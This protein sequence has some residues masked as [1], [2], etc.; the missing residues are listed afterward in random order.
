MEEEKINQQDKSPKQNNKPSVLKRSR[1]K[2]ITRS[3]NRPKNRTNRTLSDP[4]DG[5]N[6]SLHTI[7]LYRA[8]NYAKIS[9]EERVNLSLGELELVQMEVKNKINETQCKAQTYKYIN[10]IASSIV[11]VLSGAITAIEATSGDINIPII[12][13]GSIIFVTEGMH[14]LFGWGPRG[15]MYKEGNSQLRKMSRTIRNHLYFLHQYSMDKILLVVNDMRQQYDDIES[16]L[17]KMSSGENVTYNKNLDLEQGGGSLGVLQNNLLPQNSVAHEH[18][19]PSPHVHIHIE[20]SPEPN[21]LRRHSTTDIRQKNNLLNINGK[22]KPL[23]I[24]VDNNSN[25]PNTPPLNF[26]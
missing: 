4:N 25:N 17:Y 16:F 15:V 1:T 24:S 18:D 6:Q 21:S 7:P 8:R 22:N 3:Q 23:F 5:L 26:K 9:D 14:K 20:Q 13:L 2:S 11:V 19:T 12:V 10:L